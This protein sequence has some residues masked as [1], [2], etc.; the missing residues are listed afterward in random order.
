MTSSSFTPTS[1][2]TGESR[3]PAT[4]AAAS[5]TRRCGAVTPHSALRWRWLSPRSWFPATLRMVAG[6]LPPSPGR[7]RCSLQ[8]RSSVCWS[9]PE[10]IAAM[11]CS[12]W[13]SPPACVEANF[14]PSSGT[15]SISRPGRCRWNDRFTEPRGSW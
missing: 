9:K 11:S 13:R 4:M 3:I 1:S 5:P 14:W 2:K 15:T 10:R 8:R 12:C 6:F 7:C